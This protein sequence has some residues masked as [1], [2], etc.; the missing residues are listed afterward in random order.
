MKLASLVFVLVALFAAF[1]TFALV[2]FAAPSI[3]AADH[4][5]APFA[6]EV[7]PPDLTITHDVPHVQHVTPV[8]ITARAPHK[9]VHASPVAAPATEWRCTTPRALMSD[10]IATYRDCRYFPVAR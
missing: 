8:I 9:A 10:E 2:S 3:P 1:S 6:P 5:V 4:V 7:S